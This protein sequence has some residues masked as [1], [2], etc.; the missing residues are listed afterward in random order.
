MPHRS[1]YHNWVSYAG[2][3]IAALAFIAFIFLLLFHTLGGGLHAPYA[4]LVIFVVVPAF[5]ILGLLLIP[6]GMFFEWWRW[7]RNKPPSIAGYP[8]LDLNNPR[9][10]RAVSLFAIGALV[11]VFLSVYGNYR[12]YKYTESVTFCGT[13]CHRVMQPE[14]VTHAN[15]AHA[16]VRC[17]DCHVGPG[18]E[19]FVRAKI[20]GV[21][22]IYE[23]ATDN[24]PRPIPAPINEL[25]PARAICEQCHW[26]AK[27]FGAQQR[28]TVHFLP[29]EQNTRWEIDML[30]K[31]GGTGPAAP[32]ARQIHWHMNPGVRIEYFATDRARQNIPWVRL[33]DL[34]TGEATVYSTTPAPSKKQLNSAEIRTMDCM[35]CHD[36]P[37]HIFR[38][39]SELV[40]TGMAAGELD[41][42]L[43]YMKRT[44]VKLLAKHYRSEDAALNA[45]AGEMQS[46]Y[47]HNY[48][49]LASK[50]KK[51]ITRAIAYLQETYRNDFFPY[52]K[53]RWDTYADNIGHLNSLGCYR[54]HDGL[55][56]SAGG[57]AIGNGCTTCHT[58]M[59]QGTP[60]KMSFSAHPEGLPFEHPENIS[61]LWREMDCSECH[62]GTLP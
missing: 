25:R 57:G 16:R 18:A 39:P 13:L 33:T 50:K 12:A 11:L 21:K 23:V 2:T 51:S 42:A 34:N 43:P 10:R 44:A 9:H 41:P 52:M 36:R 28:N 49:D 47:Q 17:V 62:S 60:A 58:I 3:A 59:R 22:Q 14:Y 4:G 8:E 1:F 5:L 37:T 48:P 30:V 7:K 31:V 56:K 6:I 53:V 15:S 45:I 27:F 61:G 19:W 38:S 54:C 55:H 32:Q 40:N 20:Q 26:P 24:Y 29:D 46:Y 35:D